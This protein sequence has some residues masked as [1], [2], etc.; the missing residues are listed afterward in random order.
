MTRKNSLANLLLLLASTTLS[1]ILLEQAYRFHLFGWDSFSIEKMNSINTMGLAGVL[2]PSPYPEVLFELKPNLD[3]YFKLAPF[4]TSS[5]GLRDREYAVP[6]PAGVFRVAVLGDSFTMPAGLAIE[7]AF[8]SILEK[9]LNEGRDGNVYE[10]VNFAVGGYYLTQYVGVMRHKVLPYDPD[11]VLI[12]FCAANDYKVLYPEKLSRHYEPKERTYPFFS[13][14]A[15]S[16]AITKLEGKEETRLLSD[17]H[18]RYLRSGFQE[19]AAISEARDVPAVLV[20]LSNQPEDYRPIERIARSNGIE[21]FVD[22]SS[23][24]RNTELSDYRIYPTDNHPNGK[25]HILFADRIHGY[26]VRAGLLPTSA[27]P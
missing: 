19:I 25:A 8:H 6:K 26:L 12:G 13:S 21:H 14:F 16:A 7:E 24:F 20:Y 9:R 11:L 18:K 10:F 15:L 22:V 17:R 3:T 5:Q 1:L 27:Q 2:Q 23:S 4:T